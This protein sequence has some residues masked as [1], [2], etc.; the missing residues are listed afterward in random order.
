MLGDELGALRFGHLGELVL[1]LLD[2]LGLGL[3][4]IMY[5]VERQIDEERIV[6]VCL[7]ER[8]GLV[9]QAVCQILALGPI[10]EMWIGVH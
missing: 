9:G 1:E 4:R 3:Q 6:L 7:D 5:R 2:V 8:D 10:F